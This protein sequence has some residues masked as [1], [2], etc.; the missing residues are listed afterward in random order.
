MLGRLGSV[1]LFVEDVAKSV[2]FYR[3]RLGLPLK[4][5]GEDWVEFETQGTT[6]TFHRRV[7]AAYPFRP[8]LVF[9][10]ED[11]DKAYETL[12]A[13][14]IRFRRAPIDQSGG[15]RSAFC[16]DPDGNVLKI[17]SARA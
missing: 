8:E 16:V 17:T 3:D 14:G 9:T 1:V 2:E 7:E 11:A 4:A 6:L 10:V 15:A 13:A 5:R 12:Q